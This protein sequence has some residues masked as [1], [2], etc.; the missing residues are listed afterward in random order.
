MSFDNT[1]QKLREA[2]A[3]AGPYDL[4]AVASPD[5]LSLGDI[6]RQAISSVRGLRHRIANA[7]LAFREG[8][9]KRARDFV[10]GI[11][12]E[13]EGLRGKAEEV[14]ASSPGD[15]CDRWWYR[16]CQD[17][18]QPHNSDED[19]PA[20]PA[21]VSGFRGCLEAEILSIA[22]EP[23]LVR[24]DGTKAVDPFVQFSLEGRNSGALRAAD[25]EPG[26]EGKDVKQPS[27]VRFVLRE[28]SGVDLRVNVFDHGSTSF[29][30]GFEHQAFCGGLFVPLAM[31]I[32]RA[33]EAG[34]VSSVGDRLFSKTFEVTLSMALLPLDLLR[35][36]C[37]LEPASVTGALR[38]LRG[39][40][41]ILLRARLTMY[42]APLWTY[43][44]EPVQMPPNL[45]QCPGK[46]GDPLSVLKAAAASATR[47]GN[48]VNLNHWLM[49]I[50]ELRSENMPAVLLSVWWTY[51]TI[52]APVHVWP[53][54][55]VLILP[56]FT[57]KVGAIASR[58]SREEPL[59]MYRDE[60]AP[61]PPKE[62]P[63]TKPP[64]TVQK[65]VKEAVNVQLTVMQL[66]DNASLA[67]GH[68]ERLANVLSLSDRLT[69]A[70][71]GLV[72]LAV[73][74]G[75]S[76]VLRVL[77]LLVEAGFLRYAA[78]LGGCCL[79]LP[80]E[81]CEPLVKVRAAALR[82][83]AKAARRLLSLL[84]PLWLRV[85]DGPEAAH[86]ALFDRYVLIAAS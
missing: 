55:L 78:W 75:L 12:K 2:Y 46:V 83:G 50:G 44:A 38:P 79:L 19:P 57:W 47:A 8:H 30:M 18:H 4:P 29:K 62:A 10:G 26:A 28:V 41:N 31:I 21:K 51:G 64:V 45:A 85:P 84:S 81:W 40:G 68:V 16:A 74:C 37:K 32:Q 11:A 76:V 71:C 86:L 20:P 67:V 22:P 7:S 52:W 5:D 48:A 77:Q 54:L 17:A 3:A 63:P 69:S 59:R 23:A 6:A 73:A 43:F 42:T 14:A 72:A 53:L 36:R 56:L 61:E 66:V 33:R 80:D 58:A 60:V 9:E 27:S 24:E 34:L 65:A 15:S 35:S 49:A 1:D 82:E 39:H 25:R 70:L 13:D